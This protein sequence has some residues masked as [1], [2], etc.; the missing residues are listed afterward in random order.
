LDEPS[1][2]ARQVVQLPGVQMNKAG[3]RPFLNMAVERDRQ[4]DVRPLGD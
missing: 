1:D 3:R 4:R 2:L